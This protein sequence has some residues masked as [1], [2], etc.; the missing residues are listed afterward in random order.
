MPVAGVLEH[1]AAEGTVRTLAIVQA[2][3]ANQG[4]GWHV[5]LDYLKRFLETRRSAA[6]VPADVHAAFLEL[7]RY[8]RASAPPSFTTRWPAASATRPS[9]RCRSA[10]TTSP[11]TASASSATPGGTFEM[12]GAALPSLADASRQRA[13]AVL[14]A[15]ETIEAPDRRQ[16][17]RAAP[18][19]S[20]C[21]STATITSARSW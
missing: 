9:I 12:L 17:E 14:A 18:A 2:H 11:A 4:D 15:Q 5:T 8:P 20:G 1:V 16:R 19:R 6:E 21:A 13:E 7:M 10:P 3:V